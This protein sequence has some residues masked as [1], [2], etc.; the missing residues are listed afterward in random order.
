VIN[1]HELGVVFEVVKTV[2]K[3]AMS[4]QLTIIDTLVLQIG[5]LSS[6]I[7]RYIEECFPAAADGTLLQDT[8]LIIESIP[9]NVICDH[10]AKTYNLIK[11]ENKCPHCGGNGWELLSG[12][13]FLIKEVIAY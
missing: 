13:E 12:K 2:E 5:E 9:G 6:M 1:L 10:C 8:K 4:N 7:P 11:N 3:F